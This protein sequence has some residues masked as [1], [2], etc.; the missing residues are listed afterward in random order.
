MEILRYLNNRPRVKHVR[1]VR[2][3][4]QMQ[5]YDIDFI[6]KNQE[7]KEY[8]IEV[9]TDLKSNTGNI[10]VEAVSNTNTGR[11]GCMEATGADFVFY[12]FIR[13]GIAYCIEMAYF[14]E[15]YWFNRSRFRIYDK[16]RNHDDVRGDYCSAGYLVPRKVLEY[17][18]VKNGHRWVQVLHIK[19]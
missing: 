7:G 14:R 15:W 9:K 3:D 18:G 13:E 1:D 10:F 17:E 16:V 11:E 8:T 4:R 2:D 19:R 5:L 12:Y 6:V